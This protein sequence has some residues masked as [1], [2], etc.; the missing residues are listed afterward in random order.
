MRTAAH[1]PSRSSARWERAG[2]SSPGGSPESFEGEPARRQTSSAASASVIPFR[3]RRLSIC[4]SGYM[5]RGNS[6]GIRPSKNTTI[7]RRTPGAK[8]HINGLLLSTTSAP[9][10]NKNITPA[11]GSTTAIVFRPPPN[12]SIRSRHSSPYPESE[13]ISNHQLTSVAPP[14]HQAPDTSPYVP[15]HI[16]S[17]NQYRIDIRQWSNPWNH[18][19]TR[20]AAPFPSPD[21][22]APPTTPPTIPP[23]AAPTGPPT[24]AP[25]VAPVLPPTAAPAQPPAAERAPVVVA[26]A[27]FSPSPRDG[28]CESFCHWPY[29]STAKV[30]TLLARLAALRAAPAPRAALTAFAPVDPAA[31]SGT[32]QFLSWPR[33]IV[34]CSMSFTLPHPLPP[35]ARPKVAPAARRPAPSTTFLTLPARPT[36][37]LA[38]LTLSLQSPLLVEGTN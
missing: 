23:T 34:L 22:M 35:V 26:R 8:S 9:P 30:A 5:S 37:H 32:F 10:P 11:A 28:L 17:P 12:S 31:D 16:H 24:H 29:A 38:T 18:P 7:D 4:P 13:N 2:R 21:P 27:A 33:P 14:Q 20:S 6:S 36:P 1:S 25:M 19:L 3:R 15:R